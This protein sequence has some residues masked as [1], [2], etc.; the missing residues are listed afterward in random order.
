MTA[1]VHARF[2]DSLNVYMCTH[3]C[4]CVCVSV[5]V[6]VCVCVCMCA[7][8]CVCV[9]NYFFF[10]TY[11][12][13]YIDTNMYASSHIETRPHKQRHHARLVCLP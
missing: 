12:C 8:V 4:V 2:C 1:V 9:S 10:F 3:V 13:T 5:C 7:C 11:I 6:C